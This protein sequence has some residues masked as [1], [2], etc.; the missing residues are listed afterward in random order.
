MK[1][2]FNLE[3]LGKTKAPMTIEISNVQKNA[4]PYITVRFKNVI[5][6]LEGED[7]KLFAKN[8]NKALIEV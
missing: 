8:I 2:K 1:T 5:A 6:L 4:M 7:L 3:V